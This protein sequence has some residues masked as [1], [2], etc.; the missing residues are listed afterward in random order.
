MIA[1][2]IPFPTN[3]G[4]RMYIHI[5]ACMYMDGYG[6]NAFRYLNVYLI[7]LIF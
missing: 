1:S 3:V 2:S 5:Y 6:A 7:T 4:M